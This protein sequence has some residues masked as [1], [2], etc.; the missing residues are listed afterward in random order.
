MTINLKEIEKSK[1]MKAKASNGAF[2]NEYGQHFPEIAKRR[3]SQEHFT[4]DLAPQ[5]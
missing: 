5:K 2:Q 1:A 4:S 3:T